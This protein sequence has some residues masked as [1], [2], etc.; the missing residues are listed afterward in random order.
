MKVVKVVVLLIAG[1][2]IINT[3]VKAD[4]SAKAVAEKVQ[5]L[6]DKTSTLE[7]DFVQIATMKSLSISEQDNG[8]V[9]MKKDGK[10]RWDYKSPKKQLIVSDG[11]TIW[12]YM[13]SDNQV[14]IGS[15]EKSFKYKPTQTFLTGMGRI[16][17]DFNVK[18]GNAKEFAA[19][20]DEYILELI[21]KNRT[22]EAPAK[23]L[24]A[25]NKKDF[26]IMR[27]AIVD[28]FGN[29]TEIDFKNIKLNTT[30]PDKLFTFTPP[31]DVEIIHSPE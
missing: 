27:S 7:A 9:Y 6:Y 30:L 28:K 1:L 5:S 22:D 3:S 24:L 19:S 31:K 11:R 12:F 21:P 20:P 29:I 15:F 25:V 16:L 2:V 10:I 17:E 4:M 8:V 13:P 26:L 23:I 14:I 18:F